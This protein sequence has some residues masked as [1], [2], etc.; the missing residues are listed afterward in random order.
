MTELMVQA[1]YTEQR[2][3]VE[4]QAEMQKIQQEIAKSKARVEVYGKHNAKSTDRRSQLSD[5][6][7][8]ASPERWRNHLYTTTEEMHCKGM[9]MPYIT[10]S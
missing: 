2:Q 5:D 7:T 10:W 9:M 8:D 1:E 6:K 3:L 4:N